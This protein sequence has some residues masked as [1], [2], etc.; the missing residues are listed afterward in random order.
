MRTALARLS[1]E[2]RMRAARISGVA[3]RGFDFLVPSPESGCACKRMAMYLRWMVRPDDG[4]DMG[5]WKSVPPSALV[6]PVDTHIAA[7]ARELRLTGRKTADWRMAEEITARLRRIDPFD[8]V[9]FDFS[10][11]RTGM[12]SVRKDAA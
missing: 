8:P 9:R 2:V 10:L 11:C 3:G 5:V 12:V 6:I 7:I 1:D 4:I